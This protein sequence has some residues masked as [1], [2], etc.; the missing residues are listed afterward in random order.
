MSCCFSYNP[1]QFPDKTDVQVLELNNLG[2][3]IRIYAFGSKEDFSLFGSQGYFTFRLVKY[4]NGFY[5][6]EVR[7]SSS[8]SN[9]EGP[10][11]FQLR[12]DRWSWYGGPAQQHQFWPI[13]KV[14][15]HDYE[16]APKRREQI[17]VAERYWL[18]SAGSFVFFRPY[19]S[20]IVNQN[21]VDSQ[22]CMRANSRDNPI[23]SL[24]YVI[25]VGRDATQAHQYAI[26]N[27]LR[28]TT[29]TPSSD[30]VRYPTWSTGERFGKNVNETAVLQYA[31]EIERYGFDRGQL[32]IDDRWEG[33]YGTL[34]F[35][36][37]KFPN[38]KNMSESLGVRG[39]LVS[40]WIHPFVNS[41]C[42]KLHA[43][44]VEKG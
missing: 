12:P 8:T 36:E 25:G 16:Y 30:I 17:N 40:V 37:R 43:F 10:S 15:F 32:L 11:C 18:N 44:G 22:L 38:A 5:V 27:Y 23:M 9:N 19:G 6:Y 31:S 34:D 41:E 39:F 26:H 35:D 7:Q 14:K 4:G 2:A 24:E 1:L 42:K 21:I 3:D 20:L 33:C 13:E 28:E 29:M